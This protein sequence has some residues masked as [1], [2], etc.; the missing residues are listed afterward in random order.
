M[1]LFGELER[2][3][4]LQDCTAQCFSTLHNFIDWYEVCHLLTK[5]LPHVVFS[6]FF[7]LRGGGSKR[8]LREN[9][10]GVQIT[11]FFSYI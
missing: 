4:F 1:M 6:F 3:R 9:F 2:R 11:M 8:N 10:E 5:F 7:A